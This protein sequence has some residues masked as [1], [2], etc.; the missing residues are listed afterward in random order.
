M[1]DDV[2]QFVNTYLAK[3]F[4]YLLGEEGKEVDH[5]LR[6]AH[7]T[8]AKAFVLRSHTYRAGVGIALAHH[9]TTQ[10]NKRQRAE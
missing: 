2:L 4:S 9:H 5:I 7:E 10:N 3:I 1:A 8:G 6:L